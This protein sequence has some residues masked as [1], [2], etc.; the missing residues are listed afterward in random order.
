MNNEYTTR[1]VTPADLP[2][3][4]ELIG[5]PELA[6]RKDIAFEQSKILLDGSGNISGFIILRQRS[7]QDFFGG[8]IPD[9]SVGGIIEDPTWMRDDMRRFVEEEQFEL[10]YSFGDTVRDNE[11][12]HIDIY[13]VF[14]DLVYDGISIWA[15]N[16]CEYI[17][18][19]IKKRLIDFKNT[20][21]FYNMLD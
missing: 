5:C 8:E 1:S 20:I 9:G 15:E 7:L 17:A 19:P 21:S 2:Q 14:L 3:L 18:L 13:D 11:E 4:A 16:T 6:D 12:W 10:L